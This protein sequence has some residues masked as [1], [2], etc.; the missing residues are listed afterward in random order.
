MIIFSEIPNS[1][2]FSSHGWSRIRTVCTAFQ[3]LGQ[4]I[5]AV[6][7]YTDPDPFEKLGTDSIHI[8]VVPDLILLKPRTDS[9]VT[10]KLWIE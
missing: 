6:D 2:P 5:E 4:F 3:S 8:Q 10:L 9:L 7:P 1:D